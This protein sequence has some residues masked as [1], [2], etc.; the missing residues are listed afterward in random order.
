M[1]ELRPRIGAAEGMTIARRIRIMRHRT[2]RWFQPPVRTH[3]GDSE[4]FATREDPP[5]PVLSR[6][7]KSSFPLH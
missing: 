5:A 2:A 1:R 4:H 3:A 6:S 7:V